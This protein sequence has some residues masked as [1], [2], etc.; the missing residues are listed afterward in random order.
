VREGNDQL[1]TRLIRRLPA[2]TVRLGEQ[3]VALRPRG[4]GRFTA[5][6]TRDHTTHDQAADHVVLALP[7]TR[8]RDVELR[9]LDL[10][11][12]QLR[13]IRHQPLGSNAKISLQFS[14]R[15]WNA[16]GWTGDM[17]TDGIVQ[18]G[19]DTTIDQRGTA[20]ILIALPGGAE[21]TGLGRRYGLTAATG[22][23]P[24]AMAADFVD[25]FEHSFPGARA[26]FNG[27]AH[28]VWSAGDPYTGGAYSYLKVGQYTAFN[29]T[30]GQRD[31]NL[32][33]AGEHTSLNY[34]GYMEGAL[35]SGQRCA[36]EITQR[37]R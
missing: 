26:A 18:G 27:R 21:G 3:L 10:P 14:R 4:N 5:T 33:F 1:I 36:A 37:P 16:D 15:V 23:A 2:G 31:G 11:A 25:G 7:F 30:Q 19:W 28:Y 8:L 20:G 32:H 22:P 17:Y 35:R 9:G 29:G 34:L 24:A 13:A 12:P 6:F